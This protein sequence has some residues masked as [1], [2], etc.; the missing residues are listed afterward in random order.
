M[1]WNWQQNNWPDFSWDSAVLS[2]FEA[3]FQRHSGILIG[4]AKHIGE[5]DRER[6][7]VEMMVGEAV[8]S[9]EIEGEHLNRDSVQSSIRRQF[10]LESDN[11]RVPL[12]EQGISEVMVDIYRQFDEP[13]SHEALMHWHKLLMNGRDDI[14]D[15]GCY[16]THDD[17]MQVVSGPL[18]KP[19]VH[20]EAPSSGLIL[21]EMSAFVDWFNKTAPNGKAPLSSLIRAGVAHLY[22]VCIHP[23]EDGNGRIGRAVAQKVL[24]QSFGQPTLIALSQAIQRGRKRYYEQLEANNKHLDITDWLVYFAQTILEAQQDTQTMIDFL[25]EKTKLYDRLRDK[26]NERQARVLERLFRAGPEGF[27]GDLSAEN[28]IRITG[29]SRATATRDLQGMVELGALRREGELKGTRYRLNMPMPEDTHEASP[30]DH[31]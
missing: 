4:A 7:T 24:S 6:L 5:T 3:T 29:T 11:R 16:R 19:K 30:F 20:F 15:I 8:K 12:A 17:P 23:F 22:F 18:H 25:I 28:Y 27:E 2:E 13:L 1:I 26:L 9:S 21:S 10:G 14:T 31:H